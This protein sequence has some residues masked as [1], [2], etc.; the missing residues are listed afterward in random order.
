MKPNG[1]D[2]C[3]A[4]VHDPLIHIWH[5]PWERAGALLLFIALQ[6]T[7]HYLTHDGFDTSEVLP[8]RDISP[9][10]TLW[11]NSESLIP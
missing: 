9:D 8:L 5:A 7:D 10:R 4:T 6:L 3:A 1:S 11:G 2:G